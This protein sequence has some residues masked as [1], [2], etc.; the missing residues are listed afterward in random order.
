M[1]ID[2]I[3]RLHYYERQFLGAEDFQ[4]E[5]EYHRDMR[6]RHN[7]GPHT[8]GIIVGLELLEKQKEGDPGA[9]DVYLQPGLAVDGYGREIIVMLP[10]Q[11]DQTLFDSFN[12]LKHCSVWIAHDELA[13]GRPASGYEVCDETAQFG[14]VLESYR[15]VVEPNPPLHDALMVNGKEVHPPPPTNPGD[16]TIPVDETVPYQEFPDDT[17]RPR[18]L[19]RLGTVHWDG[20][21]RKFVPTTP[22]KRLNEE[23]TYA[24][25]IGSQLMAPA[26]T[27]L[28]RSRNVSDP[29]PTD[30]NDP[31]YGGVRAEVEGS[32][33]VDR[34][35]TAKQD[36]QI[37]GGKLDFRK[38]TG[39][40]D[41]QPFTLSRKDP[42]GGGGADL[43]LNIGK[44][45]AGHNRLVVTAGNASEFIVDDQG[46]VQAEGSLNLK[47]N[48]KITGIIDFVDKLGDRLMLY[49]PA[50]DPN[51]Y[52][53][54]IENSTMY[55]K[56]HFNHRWYVGKNA[57]GGGS[58]TMELSSSR[59]RLNADLSVQQTLT[60]DNYIGDHLML[61][62]ATNDPN[63]YGL[64]IES[65]T[66]YQKAHQRHRWY[67]GHNRDDGGSSS[68]MLDAGGLQVG[69]D[70]FCGRLNRWL[71]QVTTDVR[72]GRFDL[73]HLNNFFF[74][75]GTVTLDVTSTRLNFA[76]SAVLM[77]GL[78]HLGNN[79]SANDARW[80][81]QPQNNGLGLRL[82]NTTFR[83]F[84]D[85]EVGDT[86]G[87]LWAFHWIA[88]FTA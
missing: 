70:I 80:Y 13:A 9:V 78:S 34:L 88:V 71:S 24:R 64:G 85:W 42:G 68:M 72:V 69:G 3:E 10:A 74:E 6:R 36:V 2:E 8:W 56:A 12:T 39:D 21:N 50:D 7:L 25:L 40:D 55:A 38:S 82:N 49:G 53:F 87:W 27:L 14:R 19:L 60:F 17:L 81:V 45:H 30:T 48:M 65:G 1:A 62:G 79:G 16:L 58:E 52:G 46:D 77:V 22:H 23:R 5:Q 51:S 67:V 33:Q 18:W 84:I 61:W 15:L 20:V 11:L 86:D 37:H 26:D 47:G 31:S 63:A 76:S 73:N 57:D 28:I 44:E 83:W 35:L 59:L 29:L 32:L 54:G 4:A 75:N 41:G 43:L 66:L